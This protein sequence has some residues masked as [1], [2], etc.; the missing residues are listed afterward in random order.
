LAFFI[1]RIIWT[2]A[3]EIWRRIERG[4]P[5]PQAIS[6]FKAIFQDEMTAQTAA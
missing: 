6:L 1:R 3:K 5:S 4:V 2:I